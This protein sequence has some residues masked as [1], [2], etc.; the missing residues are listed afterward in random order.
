MGFGGGAPA[1]AGS[2]PIEYG[3]GADGDA[4]ITSNTTLTKDMYYDN[5]TINATFDLNADGYRVYCKSSFVING[6]L[7]N[8]GNTATDQ[9]GASATNSGTLGVGATGGGAENPGSGGVNSLG[10]VAGKGGDDGGSSGGSGGVPLAPGVLVGGI[11]LLTS[12]LGMHSMADSNLNPVNGG[13]GGG[14][15]AESPSNG[16]GGGSGGGVVFVAAPTITGSGSIDAIGGSGHNGFGP[17]GGG[18]GGGG[19]GVVVTITD[20]ASAVTV[21]VGGGSGGTG[22]GGADPGVAGSVGNS[23][24]NV[25][26]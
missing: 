9:N 2:A 10:G 24:L 14:G 25:A 23:Y 1:V 21:D 19:G 20:V 4:T 3:N 12:P 17:A 16:G 18:G 7:S 5:L 11:N 8:N 15:G 22:I 6:T 26:A 13:G